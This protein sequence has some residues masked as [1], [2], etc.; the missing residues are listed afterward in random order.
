[1]N[2]PSS[3]SLSR[4]RPLS[5]PTRTQN[6]KKIPQATFYGHEEGQDT[7]GACS[8]SENFANTNNL[9]WTKGISNTIA[10]NDAQFA[11][12]AACGMCV[13]YQGT[14]EG[15]GTTPLATVSFRVLRVFFVSVFFSPRAREERKE[16]THFF[17]LPLSL[18]LS[19]PLLVD[20][21]TTST[22]QLQDKWYRGFVNNRCP[23]CSHGDIDLNIAGDGRWKARWYAVPCAVGDSKLN[24]KIV[25]SSPYWFSLVVSNTA[26][27]ITDVQVKI[28]G[29]WRSL[30]RSNNN[31]FAYYSEAGPWQTTMP[32]P[33]R[34][35]SVTGETVED[36][37][38]STSG[39]EGKV[40]FKV[41]GDVGSP[42]AGYPG[43]GV[44]P[45]NLPN[46]GSVGSAGS[47]SPA[48]PASSSSI[49]GGNNNNNNGG[50]AGKVSVQSAGP[51]T[52]GRK[53]LTA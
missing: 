19:L 35:T 34:V 31:Q 47:K 29:S 22:S 6:S 11:N 9:P 2:S 25:V 40:Q 16:I 5:A 13:M 7:Q 1:M 4:S 45:N 39:G 15:L 26:V 21:S 18:S 41:T 43:R 51:Q 23:E 30:R 48:A 38:A 20:P 28:G 44:P 46:K 33:I 14:G 24:Y 37:V 42:G 50:A 52:G 8:F 32:L 3:P 12:G 36:T 10:L 27:P 53:L 17:F 49:G